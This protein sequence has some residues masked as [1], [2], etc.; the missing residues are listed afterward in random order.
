MDKLLEELM[1]RG[2]D[3]AYQVH[4]NRQLLMKI[5]AHIIAYN[6]RET[7]YTEEIIKEFMDELDEHHAKVHFTADELNDITKILEESKKFI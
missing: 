6:G 3:L 1:K 4:Y 5:L 7:A 2:A